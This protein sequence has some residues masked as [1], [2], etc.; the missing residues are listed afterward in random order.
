MDETTLPR[1]FCGAGVRVWS[2]LLEQGFC[3]DEHYEEKAGKSEVTKSVYVAHGVYQTV[4]E[5]TN[6]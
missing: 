2:S 1:C 5:S 6:E 4:E 3:S